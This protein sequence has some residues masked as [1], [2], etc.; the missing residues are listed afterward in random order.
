[1]QR[2]D[3]F[4]L[5]Y[6]FIGQLIRKEVS[7]DEFVRDLTTAIRR[8]AKRQGTWFRRMEKRGINIHWI[9]YDQFDSLYSLVKN[10][11]DGSKI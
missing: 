5:E 11:I 3:Y 1:M 10:N 7:K 8:F 9:D 2:L 6:K 4:G